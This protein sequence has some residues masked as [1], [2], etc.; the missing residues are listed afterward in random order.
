[1]RTD[2]RFLEM[3]LFVMLPRQLSNF[4]SYR[5]PIVEFGHRFQLIAHPAIPALGYRDDPVKAA[6]LRAKALARVR[7]LHLIALS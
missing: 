4:S 3:D 5:L 2:S 1:M 6:P 7:R